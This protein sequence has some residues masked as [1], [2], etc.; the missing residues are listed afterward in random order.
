MNRLDLL[1]ELNT[2]DMRIEEKSRARHEAEARLAEA[3]EV[4]AAQQAVDHSANQVHELRARL[5]SFELEVD[6]LG[7]KIKGVDTRLYDGRIS[8]PKELSGLEQDEVML[9]RRKSEVEDQMLEAMEQLEIA[10]AALKAQRAALDG[11]TAEHANTAARDRMVIDDAILAI[12]KLNYAREQLSAQ[13]TPAD[14][15]TYER[16]RHDKKGR[17]LSRMKGAACEACGFA[18]PSGLASR[19]RMGQ[20][21]SFCT[22]CGRILI[23]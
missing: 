22:N 18:V 20:E 6:G 21:L 17:A 5:R 19:V 3:R 23:P 4:A 2:I 9:K 8:S 7:D 16:L 10:E 13:I 1:T 12:D 14:L 15:A 11:I